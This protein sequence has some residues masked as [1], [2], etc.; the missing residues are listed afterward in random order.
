MMKTSI[1]PTFFWEIVSLR[2]H[3]C[4][5]SEIH[6]MPI[7]GTELLVSEPDSSHGEEEGF[8][9]TPTFPR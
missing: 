9:H 5:M 2:K 3:L 8:G 1:Y 7:S 6:I 4:K